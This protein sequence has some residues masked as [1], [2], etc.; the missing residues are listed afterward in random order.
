MGEGLAKFIS[1][2]MLICPFI[3]ENLTKQNAYLT[4]MFTE[5]FYFAAILF[6]VSLYS[7]EDR[8]CDFNM[9]RAWMDFK[10][11]NKTITQT[12]TDLIGKAAGAP[13]H[14]TTL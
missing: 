9:L 12:S 3:D 1:S 2:W 6:C 10:C 11:C 13:F 8:I 14:H 5:R 4:T 7:A